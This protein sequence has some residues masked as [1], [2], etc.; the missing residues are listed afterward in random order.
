M[1]K[2]IKIKRRNNNKILKWTANLAYI[3]GLITTD[4]YVSVD[5]RH[6]IF[7]SIDKQLLKTVL[8]CL[9]NKNKI[10]T[11]LPNG[12]GKKVYY[13]LQI[14][15]VVLYDF[16]VKIGLFPNKSLTIGQLRIPNKY[17]P[18]FLRGHLDGDGSIIYYKDKFNIIK[19]P[20]YIYDR[21]FV[22]FI[23]AS[24][25]HMLWIQKIIYKLKKIKGSI[26]KQIFKA[27]KGKHFLFRLKFS[28]KEAKI[29]LN[30]IYYK[31]NLPCLL[32]KF[33]IAKPFII[34]VKK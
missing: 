22:Y 2:N 10:S 9:N 27:Q 19:N 24:R 34:S 5:K 15:D 16:L 13:R 6:I 26:Q 4:G 3:I 31:K 20:K 18:D 11:N 1:S 23:S 25:R 12:I 29:I 32:R 17:F 21:L 33:T 8:F 30:W 7:T 28:T 14:G